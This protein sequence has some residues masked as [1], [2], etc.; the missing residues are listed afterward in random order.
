[1]SLEYQFELVW[2]RLV[3]K[4]GLPREAVLKLSLWEALP[5]PDSPSKL[6]QSEEVSVRRFNKIVDLDAVSSFKFRAAKEDKANRFTIRYEIRSNGDERI[7]NVPVDPTKMIQELEKEGQSVFEQ[8]F[9][10]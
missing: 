7:R 5:E 8:H 10:G 6:L 1:M 9:E 3:L 2:L 4:R